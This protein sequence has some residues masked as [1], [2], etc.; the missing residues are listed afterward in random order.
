[1]QVNFFLCGTWLVGF[2]RGEVGQ[3][4]LG[5]EVIG[6]QVAMI[7]GEAERIAGGTSAVEE[8]IHDIHVG[9]GILCSET[10]DEQ[11]GGN[12]IREGFGIM[13]GDVIGGDMR[14]FGERGSHRFSYGS[15]AQ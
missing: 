12:F 7:R 15:N 13:G 3:V 9:G 2:G 4:V 5:V 6:V 8:M 11:A 14:L 1:M 10:V